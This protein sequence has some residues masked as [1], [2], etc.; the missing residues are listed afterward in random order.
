ML[1]WNFVNVLRRLWRTSF[2]K[3]AYLCFS[4]LPF[5]QAVRLPII[6]SKYTY[7]YSLSG[8]IIIN[9]PVHFGMIRMGYIGEDVVVPQNERGLLQIEGNLKLED[10]VRL[11]CGVIIRVEPNAELVLK[12]NVRI[13]AKTRI[14]AYDSITI[15]QNTGISW[16][17][18]VIDSNM[19]DIIDVETKQCARMSKPIK[20]GD[21]CWIGTR[22]VLM[23]GCELPD[24]T[25]VSASSFCNKKYTLPDY[26][27]IAGQ[28]AQLVKSGYK[29]ADY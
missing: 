3:S 18:Q 14:I 5:R 28:P 9:G 29:R 22:S 17:C 25:I 6:V 11:G 24:F 12:K 1:N 27:V 10:N 20:I 7:F 13:G 26:S 8:K 21:N 23:K 4:M 15:G 2:I 16:E 19:H